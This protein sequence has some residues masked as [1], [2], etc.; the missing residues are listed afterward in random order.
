MYAGPLPQNYLL[1]NAAF[2]L[3]DSVACSIT[4]D[5]VDY[6]QVVV[7]DKPAAVRAARHDFYWAFLLP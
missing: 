6:S 2:G 3:S 5:L 1:W 4:Q 7:A